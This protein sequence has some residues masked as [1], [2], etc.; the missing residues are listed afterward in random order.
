MTQTI[1]KKIS[2]TDAVFSVLDRCTLGVP[3]DIAINDT[4]N[5]MSYDYDSYCRLWAFLESLVW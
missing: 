5:I 2:Y 1:P 3:L 4:A